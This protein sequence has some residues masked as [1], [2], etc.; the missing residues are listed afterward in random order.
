MVDK[1]RTIKNATDT[2]LDEMLMRLEK[3]RRV[4][5]L[6]AEL[7]RNGSKDYIPYDRPEISTEQPVETLYHFGVLG[8]KWGVRRAGKSGKAGSKGSS[9]LKEAVTATTNNL[10][11]PII[12]GKAFRDSEKASSFKDLVRRKTL[13]VNTKELRDVNQ[14][15]SK[16]LLDKK[17]A[18]KAT[19]AAVKKYQKEWEKALLTDDVTSK[20]WEKASSLYIETGKNAASRILNNLRYS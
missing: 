17:A 18:L 4:Q 8:M 13:Y 5:S 6:I 19:K 2:E 7:K 11:H 12:T 9:W 1:T 10:R 20:E 15:T 16:M 3:E 14:R